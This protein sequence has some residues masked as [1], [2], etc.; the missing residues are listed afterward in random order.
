[1]VELHE[2]HGSYVFLAGDLAYKLKKAIRF[3]FL[4]YSTAPL[5]QRMC[6]EELR[7]NHPLAPSVYL[8]VRSVIRS[9]DSFALVRRDDHPDALDYVVEMRRFDERLT[10]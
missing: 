8:G 9:A 10:L 1:A 2:T 4:D 5:R 7:V 6:R 3:E